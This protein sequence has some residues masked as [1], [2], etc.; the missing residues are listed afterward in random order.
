MEGGSPSSQSLTYCTERTENKLSSLAPSSTIIPCTYP[1][2]YQPAAAP[3]PTN[4]PPLPSLASFFILL[5]LSVSLL[6]GRL[7]STPHQLSYFIFIPVSQ[8]LRRCV[9]V[10]SSLLLSLSLPTYKSDWKFIL[11][12][13]Q[14]LGKS[15]VFVIHS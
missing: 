10:S 5:L 1:K 7:Y 8:A 11:F 13:H 12:L 3:P 9:A 6:V 4:P 14:F 15:L 2:P